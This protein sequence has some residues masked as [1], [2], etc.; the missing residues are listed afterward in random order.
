MSRNL[1]QLIQEKKVKWY[2][3]CGTIYDENGKVFE[4]HKGRDDLCTELASLTVKQL[5]SGMWRF[6]H[7]PGGHDDRAFALGAACLHIVQYSDVFEDWELTPPRKD[8]GFR[9]GNWN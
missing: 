1:L 8:G 4:E 7:N 5:P 6:D 9:M 2:P 3:G